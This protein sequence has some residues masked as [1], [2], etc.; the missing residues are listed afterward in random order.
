MPVHEAGE[1]VVHTDV[2]F[3]QDFNLNSYIIDAGGG[4]TFWQV[5]G[6][7]IGGRSS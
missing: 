2:S 7:T 4:Y 1:L 5:G 6:K 3:G